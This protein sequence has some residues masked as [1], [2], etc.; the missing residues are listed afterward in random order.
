MIENGL[1]YVRDEAFQE[2]RSTIRTGD[3]P[4]NLAA[5]RNGVLNW[6]RRNGYAQFTP[7]LRKFA[8]NPPGPFAMFG[9]PNEATALRSGPASQVATT[10]K[11]GAQYSMVAASLPRDTDFPR[12]PR[13]VN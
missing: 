8:R 12:G 7:T 13:L 9:Y 5:L 11:L 6:L 3:A 10:K 2:D 1:H 4:Q